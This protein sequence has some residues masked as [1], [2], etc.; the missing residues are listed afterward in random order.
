ML[1]SHKFEIPTETQQ[2]ETQEAYHE[3]QKAY[4]LW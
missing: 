3:T 1:Q 4:L 2:V